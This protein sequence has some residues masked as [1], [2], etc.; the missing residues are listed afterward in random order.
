MVTIKTL[1]LVKLA[2]ELEE[3]FIL[4]EIAKEREIKT[5][6]WLSHQTAW[7]RTK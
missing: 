5:T 6:K 2:L 7:R 3:D 1:E 4:G